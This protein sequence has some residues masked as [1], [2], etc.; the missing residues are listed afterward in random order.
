GNAH[1]ALIADEHFIISHEH[2]Q[3]EHADG[4]D[5][6]PGNRTCAGGYR[7][8]GIL[9][10]NGG[11]QSGTA[12][13]APSVPGAPSTM[14]CGTSRSRSAF[15]DARVTAQVRRCSV[16]SER[17]TWTGLAQVPGLL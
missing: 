3:P 15:D 12:F 17:C 11:T 4:Q 13:Y 14:L 1:G 10:R 7:I 9:F 8:A 5:S 2:H 16:G 6:S